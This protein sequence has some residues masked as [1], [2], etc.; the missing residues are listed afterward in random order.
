MKQVFVKLALILA[1][2]SCSNTPDLESEEVKSLQ[3][4]KTAINQSNKP[5]IFIDSRQLLSREQI[6]A[7]KMPILF[8]ELKF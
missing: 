5:K 6:D 1:L 4:L 3:L 8:V 2:G 7:A